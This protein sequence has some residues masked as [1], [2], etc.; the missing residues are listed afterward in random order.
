MASWFKLLE[1]GDRYVY[2]SPLL[3]SAGEH[4]NVQLSIPTAVPS[5]YCGVFSHSVLSSCLC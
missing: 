1:L 3:R 2:V 4:S 5:G